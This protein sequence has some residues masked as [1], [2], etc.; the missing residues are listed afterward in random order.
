[1]ESSLLFVEIFFSFLQLSLAAHLKQRNS[2]S[3]FQFGQNASF[4]SITCWKYIDSQNQGSL[5]CSITSGLE[6]KG[7]FLILLSASSKLI[8][9]HNS[10]LNSNFKYLLLIIKSICSETGCFEGLVHPRTWNSYKQN[11]SME[12]DFTVWKRYSCSQNEWSFGDSWN[13]NSLWVIWSL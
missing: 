12:F 11:S 10:T 1:M 6:S 7:I 4:M 2:V 8:I 13:I 3:N 5:I 9:F